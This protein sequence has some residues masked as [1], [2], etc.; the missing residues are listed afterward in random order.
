MESVHSDFTQTWN[1]FKINEVNEKY[2]DA[3]KKAVCKCNNLH[4]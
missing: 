1:D 2:H 4:V 3:L